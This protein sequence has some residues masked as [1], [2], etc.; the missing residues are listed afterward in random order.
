MFAASSTPSLPHFLL[1]SKW[2][3]QRL[4]C[5][6]RIS[7]NLCPSFPLTLQYPSKRCYHLLH[8][9]FFSVD[10]LLT[11]SYKLTCF[12]RYIFLTIFISYQNSLSLSQKLSSNHLPYLSSFS[13]T[14]I[15]T[16]LFIPSLHTFTFYK[17]VFSP[18]F[19]SLSQ[20]P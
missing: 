20:A 8:V 19:S 2:L 14:A 10:T 11:R 13:L 4:C 17:C 1:W 7:C 3:S 5:V 16:N 18:L 6:S 9:S 12:T 15:R